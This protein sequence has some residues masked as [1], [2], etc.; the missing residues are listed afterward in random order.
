MKR[1][2]TLI[3]R[4]PRL[5]A[6]VAVILLA[7]TALSALRSAGSAH[8]A[9]ATAHASATPAGA[10]PARTSGPALALASL[11]STGGQATA[12]AASTLAAG[13]HTARHAGAPTGHG[14]PSAAPTS[15]SLSNGLQRATGLTP[16]QVTVHHLCPP[17]ATGR[18]RCAGET[19]VQRSNGAAVHPHITARG[20]AHRVKPSLGHTAPAAGAAPASSAPPNAYTPAYLQ[21]AYDLA[22]L[23]Q[24]AGSGDTVAIVDAYDDPT[25]ASDLN[26]YRSFYGLPACTTANG[27]FRKVNQRGGSTP[28]TI[29]DPDWTQEISLDLDAV[30]AICPNCNILLVEADSTYL[31]DLGAAVQTAHTLGANQISNSWTAA[32]GSVPSGTYTFPGV[33][34]VAAT[35]DAGYLPP[36]Q[37]QDNYPA[38]LAGVTAAGGTTLAPSSGGANPRGFGEG[39]WTGGGSGCDRGV[40]KPTYQTDAGCHGRTY[41]DLSADA[42]PATGLAVYENGTWGIVG[43][44][45]LASPV[46][47]AY[48]AITGGANTTPQWAY[49]DSAALNDIVS[50]SNG[51]CTGTSSYICNAG[52]GYDGPTGV[53]S[54]SGDIVAGAPGIGGPAIAGGSGGNTYTKSIRADGATITGGIYPNGH[55]TTWWIQ[56]WPANGGGTAQQTPATDIGSG[57]TPVTVTGYPS[58]LTPNTQYDYQL[59]ATNTAGTIYGY[60]YSFTTPAASAT[61][62]TAAFTP[63]PAPGTTTSP[64]GFDASG[65][66]DS[67]ATISDYSWDFGDGNTTDG[68]STATASHTY[69]TPGKYNVT[70]M[71]TN[72]NG[73]S[74][75]TTQ[76]LTIDAPPVASFT[77]TPTPGVP[78]SFDASGSSDSVGTISNYSWDFGDPGSGSDNVA[79]GPN[80]AHTYAARGPY[81][82]TLTVTNDAGQTAT[83][84]Q[85]VTVDDAPTVSL[86]PTTQTTTPNGLVSFSVTATSPD[87]G[88]SIVEADWDFGDPGSAGNTATGWSAGH[89][90]AAPGTYRVAV[91]V[92]DD[93]GVATTKTGHVTVD[94]P[95]AASFTAS[96]SQ[97][98]PGAGVTFDPSGS[99][100][101]VGTL[102]SYSWN[103]G[104]PTSADNTA[105]GANHTYSHTYAT[106]GS[107]TVTLTVTN[108][109][110]QNATST[111][112]V[113]VDDPPTATLSPST[114][115]T[116]PGSAVSFGSTAASPD[117]GGSIAGYSWNFGD[118]GS[119]SANTATAPNPTHVYGTPGVYPVTM[120]VT[121]DLGVTTTKT[122]QVTVDAAPTAAFTVS[123]NPVTAGS[124][125][126]F[127]ASGSSDSVGTITG[128][129]W[130]FGDPGSADNTSTGRTPSHLY[131]TPGTYT[132]SLTVTNDAGQTTT[133]NASI[134]VNSVT[135]TTTTAPTPPTPPTTP[136]PTP[137][138]TPKPAPTPLTA[139]LGG[140]KKQKLAAV[141][142][143]G[144]GLRLTVSQGTTATFQVTLPVRHSKLAHG[145]PKANAIVL[146]R[147]RAQTLRAGTQ[148]VTLKFSRA[149]ARQLSRSGPLVLTV[150]VTLQSAGGTV[151]RTVKITL[152][153]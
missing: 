43:G 113:T 135:T 133:W 129:R 38:G 75:S 35:G 98:S 96:S 137:T 115:L 66:T 97:P 7:G 39:A 145:K 42:D 130:N 69:A 117:T 85:S 122:A 37:H 112:T 1:L 11:P 141:V 71:V 105:S 2:L 58:Q 143:H 84:A 3:R 59:V 25:A 151:T 132:V 50:G 31:S 109:A 76:T 9:P 4:H 99:S 104:D 120:V 20:S 26:A 111:H 55:D 127:D 33:A 23:S 152:T 136:T 74:E 13:R 102:T 100:D 142:P 89:T 67:G 138:P 57:T 153:R 144:L 92:T 8:A 62:P 51:G 90:Y 27:C 79:T 148:T 28:P 46:I 119:G 124:A 83:I 80:P 10:A 72:S 81:T 106:R 134:S 103:F 49:T 5:F 18:A 123:R 6:G 19:L 32:S 77:A 54:I 73:E 45:S 60:T 82:V 107:Y 44:T 70:L 64:I 131:G 34:T 91:T 41:A 101:S 116:T 87:A 52:P 12:P 86:S 48:Y 118:P 121:D 140:A 114:T 68:G 146:L 40:A 56:Y 15:Q 95:P 94:S 78:A 126:G 16:A 29:S 88:G 63:T 128:Y 149:A 139:S 93:L 22:S 14:T 61:A 110:D 36:S 108:D 150:R 47:A 125:V 147:T 24:T 53:G 21:Q 30:S 17:V 65:S